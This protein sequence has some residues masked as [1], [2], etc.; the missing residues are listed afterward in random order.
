MKHITPVTK[1]QV[2]R[3]GR[4]EDFICVFAQAFNAMLGF[5]GGASPIWLYI[6]EKCDISE[7]NP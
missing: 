4:W 7:P 1:S 6:E 5:L 3:A 2:A